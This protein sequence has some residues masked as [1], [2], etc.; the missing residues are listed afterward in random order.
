MAFHLFRPTRRKGV[1]KWDILAGLQGVEAGE[2]IRR[3][4]L[5]LGLA[6]VNFGR[7]QLLPSEDGAQLGGARAAL[8]EDRRGRLAQAMR[9]AMRQASLVTPVAK[10]VAKALLGVAP[11][12][13]GDNEGLIACRRRADDSLQLRPNRDLNAHGVPPPILVLHEVEVAADHVLRPERVDIPSP[14]ASVQHESQR[15]AG[16]RPDR[17]NRLELANFIDRPGMEALA[18]DIDLG[19]AGRRV[20]AHKLLLH[21]PGEEGLEVLHQLVGRAG[22]VAPLVPALFD[23][24]GTKGAERQRPRLLGVAAQ[25]AALVLLRHRLIVLELG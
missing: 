16:R 17:M 14:A 7:L 15:Q 2:R 21:R 5:P 22:C 4:Q 19:N 6:D 12:V 10:A 20:A 8:G 11:A 13:R 24:L 1:G 23:I 18:P 3:H 25:D 9:G